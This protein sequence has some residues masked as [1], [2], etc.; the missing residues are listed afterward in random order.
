MLIRNNNI[1]LEFCLS[2]KWSRTFD[3]LLR[4]TEEW[5][6]NADRAR[7]RAAKKAKVENGSGDAPA[8]GFDNLAL[9]NEE[10]EGT[11]NSKL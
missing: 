2:Q 10:E 6:K 4:P 1:Y 3:D 8:A 5:R 7:A 11:S 9:E